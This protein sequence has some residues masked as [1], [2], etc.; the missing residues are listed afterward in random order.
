MVK[1][2]EKRAAQNRKNASGP[3]KIKQPTERTPRSLL[4]SLRR[5]ISNSETPD[6]FVAYYIYCIDRIE[7]DEPKVTYCEFYKQYGVKDESDDTVV[8]ADFQIRDIAN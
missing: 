8:P 3:R 5:R 7:R 4:P 2:Q 6:R 1:N